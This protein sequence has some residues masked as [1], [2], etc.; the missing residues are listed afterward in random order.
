MK[1][2]KRREKDRR[3]RRRSKGE[4]VNNFTP[5]HLFLMEMN[6]ISLKGKTVDD[7]VRA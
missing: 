2:K 3:R 7:N 5:G 1:V 4:M 6:N